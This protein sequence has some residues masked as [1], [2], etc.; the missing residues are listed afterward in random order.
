MPTTVCRDRHVADVDAWEDIGSGVARGID[1]R[2][3]HR[4]DARASGGLGADRR[5]PVLLQARLGPASGPVGSLGRRA[6]ERQS[7]GPGRTVGV[8]VGAAR[9]SLRFRRWSAVPDA[10]PDL[11]IGGTSR[12]QRYSMYASL[13]MRATPSGGSNS[14]AGCSPNAIS[15]TS[16]VPNWPG[17]G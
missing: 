2:E 10:E 14:A 1:V 4:L 8:G 11:L 5:G 13:G 17:M 12:V 9:R 16:V 7:L 3:R 15:V 6:T